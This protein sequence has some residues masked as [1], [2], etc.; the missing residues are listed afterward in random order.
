MNDNKLLTEIIMETMQ[1]LVL[2][3]EYKVMSTFGILERVAEK[4]LLGMRQDT[5]TT[6]EDVLNELGN[7]GWELVGVLKG[8]DNNLFIFKRAKWEEKKAQGQEECKDDAWNEEDEDMLKSCLRIPY[9]RN[10]TE[11]M[12]T[13]WLQSLKERMKGMNE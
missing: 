2:K 12:C 3:Y 9:A 6:S 11:T 13:K 5:K 1:E 8:I 7:D 10:D 4:D